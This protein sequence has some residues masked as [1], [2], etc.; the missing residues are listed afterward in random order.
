MC[1]LVLPPDSHRNDCAMIT[2]VYNDRFI[3]QIFFRWRSSL[4]KTSLSRHLTWQF[5]VQRSC[6]P[7]IVRLAEC[8]PVNTDLV[9]C[10][11]FSFGCGDGLVGCIHYQ[12]P[13][14]PRTINF[15]VLLFYDWN[16]ALLETS[17]RFREAQLETNESPMWRLCSYLGFTGSFFYHFKFFFFQFHTSLGTWSAFCIFLFYFLI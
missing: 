16:H 17:V 4:A 13:N 15:W 9:S 10:Q 8:L 12:S 14:I 11:F 6:L 2:F 5:L 1:G 3:W 7:L